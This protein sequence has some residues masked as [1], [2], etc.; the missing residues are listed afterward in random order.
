V[1]R[2]L[3]RLDSSSPSVNETEAAQWTIV[4]TSR[5]SA[6]IRSQGRP[7]AG[8]SMS[9]A[10]AVARSA[11]ASGSEVTCFTTERSRVDASSEPGA[12]TSAY[13]WRSLCSSQRART[14]MPMKPVTPVISTAPS[15]YRDTCHLP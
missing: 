13:T 2:T 14:S 15:S 6:S 3:I 11:W 12:R 5:A 1:P 9:A 8:S 7:S 10:T 4:V